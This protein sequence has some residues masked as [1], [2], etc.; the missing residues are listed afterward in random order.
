MAASRPPCRI[1]SSIRLLRSSSGQ[2]RLLRRETSLRSS[3]RGTPAAARANGEAIALRQA[4]LAV[5]VRAEGC[6]LQDAAAEPDCSLKTVQRDQHVLEEVFVEM[7][8]GRCPPG[9]DSPR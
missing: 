7:R 2:L 5:L 8:E 4:A 6:T 3:R 9:A 1:Q